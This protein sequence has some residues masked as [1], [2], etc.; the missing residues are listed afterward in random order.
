MEVKQG[1]FKVVLLAVGLFAS[2]LNIALA[3][4][5]TEEK[6]VPMG[7]YVAAYQAMDAF[8]GSNCGQDN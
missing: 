2:S 7:Q 4:V 8:R 6:L 3:Q 1:L 5:S